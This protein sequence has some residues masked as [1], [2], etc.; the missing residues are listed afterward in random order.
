MRGHSKI[1]SIL[2][3]SSKSEHSSQKGRSKQLIAH[4]DECLVYRYFFYAKIKK[5][6]YD[7]SLNMLMKE[8]FISKIRIIE[9]LMINQIQLTELNKSNIEVKDLAKRFPF[10]NWN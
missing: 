3:E 8:F 9:L 6:Q 1:F 7:D 4:R 10:Y 2:T 5:L